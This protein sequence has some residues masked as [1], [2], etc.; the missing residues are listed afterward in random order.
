MARTSFKRSFKIGA[1]KRSPIWSPLFAA[2]GAAASAAARRLGVTPAAVSRNVAN[3]ER[4]LGVRL[5]QRS[6]RSLTLTEDGERFLASVSDGVQV[7]PVGDRRG[8]D[9]GRQARR[10][11]EGQRAHRPSATTIPMPLLPA[12]LARYPDVQLDR[13]REPPGRTW[14]AKASTPPSAAA[15]NCRR[16]SSPAAAPAAYYRRGF[17]GVP[18]GRPPPLEPDG[19]AALDGLSMRS[20]LTGRVRVWRMRNREGV[21]T[22]LEHKRASWPTTRRRYAGRP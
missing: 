11:A 19:L 2:P 14:S 15:W 5:F 22:T 17:T 3:L 21:E 13:F 7:H 16:G 12:F 20:A 4:S 8:D 1:W 18:Q 6:S 10:R 9:A